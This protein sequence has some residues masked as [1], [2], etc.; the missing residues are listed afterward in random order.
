MSMHDP[1]RRPWGTA[2]GARSVTLSAW[3]LVAVIAALAAAWWV[4]MLQGDR[5]MLTPAIVA[6][7]IS[8]FVS[9]GAVAIDLTTA[10]QRGEEESS[11]LPRL[12][13]SWL[14]GA[15]LGAIAAGA[16]TPGYGLAPALWGLLMLAGG[17]TL[18]LSPVLLTQ[19]RARKARR[20]SRTRATGV[21][22]QATVTE[23]RTFYREHLAR[24]RVTMRFTDQQGDQRWFTQTAAAGSRGIETGQKLPLHYDPVRPGKTRTLVIDWPQH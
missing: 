10:Q 20:H 5:N 14:A 12:P 8:I 16:L 4:G 11:A 7:N 1:A 22:T 3:A 13:G 18:F 24:Y 9:L 23:V 19:H 17:V 6:F 21:R 15:G 2:T